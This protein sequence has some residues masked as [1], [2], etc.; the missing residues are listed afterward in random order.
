MRRSNSSGRAGEEAVHGR[1]E[2]QHLRRFRHVVHLAVGDHDDAGEAI[3]RR[4]GE[5]AVEVGEEVRAGGRLA[6]R[7]GGVDPAHLQ[8]GDAAELGL[9]LA[10]DGL[11][12]LGPAGDGLAHALV[13]DDDGDVGEALALLLPQRRVGERQ[14]QRGQRQRPEQRAPVAAEEQQGH[15][16]G[17]QHRARPEQRGAAA[18]ARSRSTSCSCDA[19]TGSPPPCA[20]GVRGGGIRRTAPSGFPPPLSL[21]HKGEGTLG[22]A[23]RAPSSLARAAPAAPARAPDRPCSCR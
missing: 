10:A 17:S 5:R 11:R 23:S 22:V 9:E 16:D 8:V 21:P 6:R 4:V 14:Q 15:Q 13:D 7:L 1:V 20:G 2:A 18:S 19:P 12:L 3:G